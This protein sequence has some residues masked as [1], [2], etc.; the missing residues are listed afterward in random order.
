MTMQVSTGWFR[1]IA[2]ALVLLGALAL[3][4]AC[5]DSKPRYLTDPLAPP[6]ST[7]AQIRVFCTELGQEA[8]DWNYVSED[9]LG[10]SLRARDK[11]FAECMARH[12]QTP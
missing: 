4:G 1:P 8:G 11:T 2:A 12:H 7:P 10:P 3:L 5:T 6:G 9:P